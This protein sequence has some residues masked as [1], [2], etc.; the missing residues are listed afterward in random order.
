MDGPI[1]EPDW[2]Y[3]RSIRDEL[4]NELCSR[5][6]RQAVEIARAEGNPLERYKALY[7]HIEKSDEVVAD[8]FDD[9][10]RSTVRNTIICLRHHRLLTDDHVMHMSETAQAWLRM[11]EQSLDL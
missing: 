1:L 9:W 8:C 2:K 3:L 11:V 10:R 7:R 5:I 4:I 6:L